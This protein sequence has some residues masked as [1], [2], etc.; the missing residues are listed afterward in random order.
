MNGVYKSLKG[1]VQETFQISKADATPVP[2]DKSDSDLNLSEEMESLERALSERV[3]KLKAAVKQ[4]EATRAAAA[5]EAGRV[6]GNL[7]GTIAA[8]DAKLKETE[9]TIRKKDSSRQQIEE[10]LKARIQELLNDVKKKE[11]ALAT[12]AK[13]VNDLRSSFEAKL[14]RFGEL[15]S[16]NEKAKQEAASHAKRA[17][18]LAAVSRVKIDTLES[19]L[20]ERDELARQKELIIKELEQKL[21]AKIQD[22]E[23]LAK[24]KQDLLAGRDAVISDLKSQLKLLTKGIGEMSS[25]FKQAQAFAVLERQDVSP[26]ASNAAVNDREEKPSRPFNGTKVAP[27]GEQR[28]AAIRSNGV[29][30]NPFL[31]EDMPAAV[32]SSNG[33]VTPAA[34]QEKPAAADSNERK[35][36][37]A[38][39]KPAPVQANAKVTA[40]HAGRAP[41][42]LSPEVFDRIAGELSEVA[43]VMS[44]LAILIVR[45]HV[46]ALG[47][48]IE[49][50]PSTR[51]PELLGSVS[52]ELLDEKRQIVFRK[53]LADNTQITSG[54]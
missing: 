22:F 46:E 49:K 34:Q 26:G 18:D 5:R 16:A 20:K 38:E 7:K 48:S 36:V 11:E 50:F 54:S 3:G 53:R 31:Q 24:S 43:G 39:E 37:L 10:T 21:A 19:Q 35:N 9:E 44:P 17:D 42:I 15:E 51:L 23:S 2:R 1:K 6:I 13:E 4:G 27:L 30:G 47:E 33:K 41:E 28:P 29:T 40:V 8:L 45:N 52:R 32:Q 14:K 25:F 12:Q